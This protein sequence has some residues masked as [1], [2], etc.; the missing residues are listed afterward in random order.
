M[1]AHASRG[2]EFL[3]L[4]A[5]ARKLLGLQLFWLVGCAAVL[6]QLVGCWQVACKRL[7]ACRNRLLNLL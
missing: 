4:L 1:L 2:G 7:S 5:V 6:K 3:K